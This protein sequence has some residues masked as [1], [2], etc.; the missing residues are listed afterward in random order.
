MREK[1]IDLEF[2]TIFHVTF[3]TVLSILGILLMF[4][5]VFTHG[6]LWKVLCPVA[7]VL[8]LSCWL[9][10]FFQVGTA[11]ARVWFYTVVAFLGV[12]Y[13]GGHSKA[14]TDVPIVKVPPFRR[15]YSSV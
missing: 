10:H 9:V 5:M 11:N 15:E 7:G 14:L 12:L 13:Y 1:N 3:V 4:V 2:Q 6:M 8:L